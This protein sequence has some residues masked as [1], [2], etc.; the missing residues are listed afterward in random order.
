MIMKVP[1]VFLGCGVKGCEAVFPQKFNCER[2]TLAYMT[3][4]AAW[5]D[6]KRAGWG[7]NMDSADNRWGWV[8]ETMF[9]CP[10]HKREGVA[11]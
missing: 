2:P 7:T 5:R 4:D 3:I 8:A 1:C 6:A 9:Y 10:D 11:S